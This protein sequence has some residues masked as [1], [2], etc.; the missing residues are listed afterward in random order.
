MR[1][2]L[3]HTGTGRAAEGQAQL[4]ATG[5]KSALM[6]CGRVLQQRQGLSTGDMSE[7]AL[8]MCGRVQRAPLCRHQP[9]AQRAHT[10]E[11][12]CQWRS[13]R[14]HVSAARAPVDEPLRR[15]FE[16]GS[17]LKA[18]VCLAVPARTVSAC[19]CPLL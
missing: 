8:M 13:E 9:V 3:A 14:T 16:I 17:P 11:W 2:S 10:C 6:I 5:D 1:D 7:S 15:A 12:G 19:V 4:A 18:G